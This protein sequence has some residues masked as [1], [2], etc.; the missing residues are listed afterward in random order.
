MSDDMGDVLAAE[1]AE[2]PERLWEIHWR[3]RITRD[4][5]MER[6]W[7]STEAEAREKFAKEHGQRREI[8]RVEK[9]DH[10]ADVHD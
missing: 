1:E 3:G 4:V 6:E 9:F 8:L 2:G 7:A 10:H 5:G